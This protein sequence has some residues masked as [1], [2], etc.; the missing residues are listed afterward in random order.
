MARAKKRP[1]AQQL[2]GRGSLTTFGLYKHR[3]C[4]GSTERVPFPHAIPPKLQ[5]FR[6]PVRFRRRPSTPA[7]K[8]RNKLVRLTFS[9]GPRDPDVV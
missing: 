4:S 6:L 9:R 7:E 3:F 2:S 5:S 1:P 8:A